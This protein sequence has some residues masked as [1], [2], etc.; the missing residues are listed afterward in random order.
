MKYDCQDIR[1]FILATMDAERYA[2]DDQVLIAMGAMKTRTLG[3]DG[4]HQLKHLFM[5]VLIYSQRDRSL[6][7]ALFER[8]CDL[9]HLRSIEL[10]GHA[11]QY[12]DPRL[13][14][15]VKSLEDLRVLLPD[16]NFADA[17][18][19]II[20]ALDSRR[21]GGLIGLGIICS[22]SGGMCQVEQLGLTSLSRVPP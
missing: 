2:L 22:V 8:L 14:G 9:T 10:S 15:Q 7:P 3:L 20:K 5:C 13:L 21:C 16:S 6:K 11:H 19:G 4:K 1:F 12:Y 17:M 18:V